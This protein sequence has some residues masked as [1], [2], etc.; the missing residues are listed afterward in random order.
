MRYLIILSHT[1]LHYNVI[2]YYTILYYT[3][4]YYTMLYYSIL[5]YAIRH[6]T[7]VFIYTKTLLLAICCLVN[8]QFAV[9]QHEAIAVKK[10]SIVKTANYTESFFL[11]NRINM[12]AINM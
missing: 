4:L 8:S 3:I 9:T 6:Y 7:I 5:Y 1:M 11:S 10:Q 2:P 12:T